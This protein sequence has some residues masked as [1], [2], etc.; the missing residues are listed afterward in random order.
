MILSFIFPVHNEEE[1]LE[2]QLEKFISFVDQKYKNKF[3]IILVENGSR[4]KSW[5]IIKKLESKHKFI[6]PHRLLN[7]SYGASI[8]WGIINAIGKKIFVLNVDYFDFDFITKSD[9]LLDTIDLVIGSKTLTSSNDRRPLNRRMGTYLFNVFLRLVLNYPGTDT[10]GIKAFKKTRSL[11]S[12]AK[13]CH[14]Q[15]ELFDTELVLRLTKNG[16]IFVDLPQEIVE[17]R[18]SRYFGLRRVKSTIQDFISIIKTKYLFKKVFMSSLIDADDF[19]F[20]NEVN[21]AIIS[22][23]KSKAIDV[24]SIVANLVKK[25]DLDLL[26]KS[27]DSLI[28]SMHFNLLRGKPCSKPEV[29]RSLVNSKGYFFNLPMFMLKLNL[30]QINLKEIEKEFLAQYKKLVSMGCQPTHLSSEQHLHIFSPINRFL[31]KQILTTSIKKI[32]SVRSSFHSLDNKVL[33]KM[34]LI[35][36]KN[37]CIWRFGEFEEFNRKYDAQIAHPGAS[38]AIF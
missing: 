20:S 23:A 36:F 14:T 32:R 25:K 26:Q 16:A 30:G 19:G 28:Y 34:F 22:E 31:E 7:P 8:R 35:I 1:F 6:K 13:A 5:K 12:V 17:L 37:L 3:E 24:V 15:N 33:R 4:D 11:I 29:I 21:Q 10:H 9:I 2:I 18:G 27:S 38:K